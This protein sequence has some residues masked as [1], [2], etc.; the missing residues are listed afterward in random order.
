[1]AIHVV[2]GLKPEETA[3]SNAVLWS[4]LKNGN[5][6][7]P[8]R[9]LMTHSGELWGKMLDLLKPNRVVT[10]GRMGEKVIKCAAQ[11]CKIR[12]QHLIWPLPSPRVL[13]PIVG[14]MDVEKIFRRYP[15]IARAKKQAL[16][17][18]IPSARETAIVYAAIASNA[19]SNLA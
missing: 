19:K 11:F 17:W 5:N 13:Y 7:T 8:S 18:V 4:L 6:D 15:E 3:V 10:A 16:K 9:E 12:F 1:M 2:L 14:Y